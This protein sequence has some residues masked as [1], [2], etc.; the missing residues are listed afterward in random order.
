M[1][2]TVDEHSP[3]YKRAVE[4]IGK[5]VSDGGMLKPVPGEAV[6]FFRG[7]R[8]RDKLPATKE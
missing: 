4:A 2:Q 3:T 6:K 5:A 7:A 1:R 8:V